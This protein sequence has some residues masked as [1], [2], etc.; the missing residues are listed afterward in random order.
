MSK[1]SHA[2]SIRLV[3]RSLALLVSL[4]LL[5]ACGT[6]ASSLTQ[7]IP[8]AVNTLS[9]D[10]TAGDKATPVPEISGTATPNAAG[11]FDCV[12]VNQIPVAECAALV[13]LY[14]GTYGPDWIDGMGW[15]VTNTPCSW[16][17]ITC[18]DGH[19]SHISL[20]YNQ[21]TGPLPL[22]LGNL[23]HLLVLDLWGNQ[24]SG[25][26]PAELG[27]LSELVSLYLGGNL[28]TSPLPTELGNLGKLKSLSL[29]DNQL[30][31]S[32]PPALGKVGN[33]ESLDLS[34]NR[35]S[36]AIPTQL[37]ELG[38]L[39]A[40]YL[41]HNQLSG[42]I[43]V[44]FGNLSELLELD[45]SYNQLR[46]AVPESITYIDQRM[47]WGNQ[48]EG[49]ITTNGQAPFN[50]D[51]MGVH[52]S[53]DP[54]LATSIWPE[55]KPATPLPEVLEGPSYWLAI[56]EHI[57]FTFADPG[58]PPERR[59]MGFN[60]A[61]EAQIL[62]FPLAELA[63]M[64]PLVQTQIET[65]RN[66]L[67]ERGTVPSGELPL[68]PLTNSAQVFHAQAQ[69]LEF[70][71]IQGLRFISQ[72]SQ[73][74]HPI[75]L[76]QEL[77]YTF[78]GFTD[79]GA[80]Y[81]A[82]FFPLTTAALPDA[83]E[84][85]DWEAFHANYDT[86]LLETT[87]VLDQLPSTEFTPD[88]PLVDAVVT[89]LQIEPGNAASG[90]LT[91]DEA[92]IVERLPSV[93]PLELNIDPTAGLITYQRNRQLWLAK[94]DLSGD[95]LKLAE[96]PDQD[97]VICYQP[98]VHWSPDGSHFFYEITVDGEHRILVSDLQGQQQGYRISRPPSRDPVWS[99]DGNSIIFFVVDPNRPWGDHSDRDLSPLDFGFIDEVWQLQ[100]DASGRWLAPLKLT[101]LE[102][103]GIGCGGGGG[104]ISD[105]LY[106]IQGG[107][108]LGYHA[109]RKMVWTND[110]VIIY[111]LTCDYWQGYGRIDTQTWQPLEP[112]SGLLR[113]LTLDSSGSRWYAVTGLNRD[114]DPNNNRLVT[115]TAGGTAYEVIETAVPV[116]MVFVGSY[117][118]RLYYTAREQFD[119]KDLSEQI[120][121]NKSVPPYFNFYHTQLWTILPDGTDER[122]LWESDDH[123]YSRVTETMHG[124]FLFVLVENDVDLYEAIASGAPEEEWIEH[125]PHTHIMRLSFSDIEPEIWLEDAHS[126]T[127]RYPG[128]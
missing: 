110:D 14:N 75:M 115:G 97:T 116:E 83:I 126:L 16:S 111:P 18:T 72:H 39:Y 41:S 125:L 46:G 81:V 85:E 80:Y 60:L 112:Y 31:G 71:N 106:D 33:L 122:L 96:C 82:V 93:A 9:P 61:A 101:D 2:F 66:L 36:G 128:G 25:P 86:Y 123:S 52:F 10:S 70:G 20:S 38:N 64:N 103:P 77:F 32:I 119:H 42:S 67:A 40:L 5:A 13:A 121:W 120:K 63:E 74:P 69:Y 113:G 44:T 102:T 4:I 88:L 127:T 3:S 87:A 1:H 37:G 100:K 54:S 24:L 78:Q 99:P 57:R 68:L 35:F 91:H 73:D 56:P 53:A 76:S 26:I 8:T 114:D 15:L 50:V 27:N 23:S 43:P 51:Y 34:Y 109:A 90:S 108:A 48:L 11:G 17:G 62:V 105:A 28:L 19:V 21:L 49:T 58:L 22:E 29:A 117:S 89:S 104:S 94:A 124:D 118:G 55:V 107:F 92:I 95:P 6:G 45:L 30:S 65:L 7:A 79:D 12:G 47:L 59:R 84:V 98:G